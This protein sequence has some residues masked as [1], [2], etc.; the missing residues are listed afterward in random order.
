MTLRAIQINSFYREKKIQWIKA[1]LFCFNNGWYLGRGCMHRYVQVCVPVGMCVQARR[2]FWI[3]CLSYFFKTG[4]CTELEGYWLCQLAVQSAS[5]QVLPVSTPQ[6]WVTG[7]HSHVQFFL[8]CG[9][10]R[11]RFSYLYS[12]RSSHWVIAPTPGLNFTTLFCVKI[13]N[14]PKWT[15]LLQGG[16]TPSFQSLSSRL[17]SCPC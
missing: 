17:P 3:S 12:K 5:S 13:D 9:G 15:A 1:F 4:T 16:I 7:E 11:L 2:R 14:Q 6:C 8:G 10:C